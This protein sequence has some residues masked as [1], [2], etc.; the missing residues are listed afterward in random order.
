MFQKIAVL[1]LGEYFASARADGARDVAKVAFGN[2]RLIVGLAIKM[3]RLALEY[4]DQAYRCRALRFLFFNCFVDARLVGE[5]KEPADRRIVRMD[6]ASRN[7]CCEEISRGLDPKAVMEDLVFLGNILIEVE[8]GILAVDIGEREEIEVKCVVANGESV[9][10]ECAKDIGL[11]R[12]FDVERVFTCED[13][14]H[15][16]CI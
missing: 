15:D 11:L 14:S 13:G 2:E 6:G 5:V 4:L 9:H 12:G 1:T 10:R 8:E 16:V 3:D 7:K